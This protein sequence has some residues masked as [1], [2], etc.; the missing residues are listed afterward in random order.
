MEAQP[1]LHLIQQMR[2][3]P[4]A[5]Q[6][7]T[8]SNGSGELDEDVAEHLTTFLN[9]LACETIESLKRIENQFISMQVLTDACHLVC[10]PPCG[11]VQLGHAEIVRCMQFALPAAHYA[12]RVSVRKHRQLKGV[13]PQ[14]WT[15]PDT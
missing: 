7:E 10:L 4:V 1:K 12:S 11:H 8:V 5:S 3:A 15:S 9:V 6:W 2:V 13:K 14:N